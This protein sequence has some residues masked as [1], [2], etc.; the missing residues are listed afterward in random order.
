MK[1]TLYLIILF[2]PVLLL[3]GQKGTI[4]FAAGD[5]LQITADTYIVNE[6][7]APLIILFHQA[8][9]SRGEYKEI[10]PKLN[11]LGFN[12]LAI[13]QRSGGEVNG[14][15]NETHRNATDQKKSTSYLDAYQDMQA[16]LDY[17]KKHFAKS[18]LIVWGSSYSASLV[19]KLAANNPNIVDGV[20]A[21]S[22]GEYFEKLGKDKSY[23]TNAVTSLKCPVFITSTPSE[24]ESWLKIFKTIPSGNKV[25]FVPKTKGNHGSRALWEKFE[26]SN[27]YWKAVIKFLDGYFQGK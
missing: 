11:S 20:L 18:K 24:K 13:D 17:T 1:I 10:A 21:F 2:I 27:N 5:G 15:I 3:A 25:S 26:D 9:W 8:G 6:D 19:L 14:V 7:D 12:C 23:I 4:T 22:P 16:A